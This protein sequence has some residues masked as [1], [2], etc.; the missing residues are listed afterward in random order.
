MSRR[1]T[2][3]AGRR[4]GLRARTILGPCAREAGPGRLRPEVVPGVEIAMVLPS[5][6]DPAVLELKD[7]TEVISQLLALT[8]RGVALDAHHPIVIVGKHALQSGPERAPRLLPQP[9][10]VRESRLAAPVVVGQRAPPRR[11]PHSALVEDFGER[12][13][14]AGVEGLVS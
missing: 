14:V 3:R 11:M 13:H 8:R 5:L 1:A 7:Q 10:E 4:G 2:R 12:G 6:H 9:A